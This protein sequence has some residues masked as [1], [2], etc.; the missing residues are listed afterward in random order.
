MSLIATVVG[1]T[2]QS[3]T[4]ILAIFSSPGGHARI[5]YDDAAGRHM[6][7]VPIIAASPYG[8]ALFR[9]TGISGNQLKY[10]VGV[11]ADGVSG[12]DLLA[13]G[14]KTLRMLDPSKP[15]RIALASCNDIDNHKFPKPQRPALWTKLGELVANDKVDLIVHAGDQI[16]ADGP[17]L[18]W[19]QSEGHT[20]A[21]RRHYVNTWSHPEVAKVLGSCPNLMMWDDHEIYDGWGSND[22]D[23][24]PKAQQRFQAAAQAF[25]EFQDALN[26][27]DRLAAGFGWIAKY[28]DQAII[29]VDGRTNRRWSTGTILGKAQLDDLELQLHQLA[30]SDPKDRLKH[31]YVVVGTPVVYIPLLVVEKL[32]SFVGRSL[33]DDIRDGWS[34]SNNRNECRRFLMSLMNF[35]G[36]S[37]ETQVT[38]IAGDI[39]VGTLGQIDTTLGFGP[40]RVAPRIYQVTASGIGRP[41]PSGASALGIS[42][43]ASGA[44]QELFNQ[45]IQGSLRKLSGSKHPYCLIERNFAVLDPSNGKGDDQRD[46]DARGNLW[47]KFHTEFSGSSGLEQQ[48]PKR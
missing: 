9:L 37:P 11:A 25:R 22:E 20:V 27:P 23:V 39:H 13:T 43:V 18:G 45:D 33:L 4:Q 2:S 46:W 44:S 8:L 14:S 29:A 24:S 40:G 32:T 15:L 42:L 19:S 26:P 30:R 31:L 10:A 38:I 21:Y 36:H 3:T 1:Y 16:Y 12:S 41:A 6:R 17:P 5:A 48:L 47:V 35:A 34:A 7:D 28:K